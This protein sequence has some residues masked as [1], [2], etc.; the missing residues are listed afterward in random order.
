[1]NLATDSPG[2]W[3]PS[4]EVEPLSDYDRLELVVGLQVSGIRYQ[5]FL[6]NLGSH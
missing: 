6:F 5:A 4:I 2:S 1:M 3:P